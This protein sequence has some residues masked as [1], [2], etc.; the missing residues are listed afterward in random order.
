M[1]SQKNDTY[2]VYIETMKALVKS[3]SPSHAARLLVLH[4]PSEFLRIRAVSSIRTF[5]NKHEGAEAL[6]IEASAL[7]SQEFQCL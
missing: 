2:D 6:D 7:D 4:G 1:T 3:E 5:W